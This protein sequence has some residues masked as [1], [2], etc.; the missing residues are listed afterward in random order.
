MEGGQCYPQKKIHSLQCF[1]YETRKKED[2]GIKHSSQHRESNIKIKPR[3]QE[4]RNN[5]FRK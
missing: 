4:G 5:T 2:K 1:C 3:K